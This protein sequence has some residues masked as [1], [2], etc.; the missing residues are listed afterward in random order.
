MNE[1]IDILV[2]N[3]EAGELFYNKEENSYGFNYK[4]NIPISLIMPFK[5]STYLWKYKLHP[6]FEM[7]LPEGFLYEIFKNL[8]SKEHGYIN[9]FL[10]LSYLAPNIE[11]RIEYKSNF[12][13]SDFFSFNIEDIVNNDTNDT[14][15]KILNTF[16]SRNAISGVQ[17]KTLA[18]LTDKFPHYNREFIIK[19]WG[20]NY[21]HLSENEYFCLK[22][23]EYSGVIIPNI[24]LSKH[25]NFLLVERFNYN[26]VNNQYTGFEEVAGLLGKNSNEKYS[27]SYEKIAKVIYS[28]TSNK[29]KDMEYL[30]KIVTM[31][32]LL[33]NGDAHLKN[34]G[35]IYNSSI[36]EIRLAPAYDI[37]NTTSY[38]YKDRPALTLNGN[39]IWPGKKDIVNFG[40]NHC[41]IPK[42]KT[43]EYYDKCIDSVKKIITEIKD[44][45]IDNKEFSSVGNKMID[46]FKFFIKQNGVKEIPDEIIRNWK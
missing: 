9:D 39:K 17:P 14:F 19:T 23:V 29:L 11:G 24:I 32:Y 33:G 35:V 4:N 15:N 7:N 30:F 12:N 28:V 2:N 27:G 26:P 22:A 6:I 42:N 40:I 21:P 43:L 34:F 5:K 13:K 16:L 8:L 37:I 31:N 3:T 44:Y 20:E 1:K 36:N 41:F 38:I 25:K 18:V 10:I 46:S 45:I